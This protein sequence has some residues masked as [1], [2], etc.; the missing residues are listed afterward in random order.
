LHPHYIIQVGQRLVKCN[1]C[2]AFDWVH[3]HYVSLQSSATKIAEGLNLWSATASKHSSLT[4]A[5]WKTAKDMYKMIDA[6][7]IGSLPFKTHR[8]F[9]KGPKPSTPPHWMEEAYKLDARNVLAVVRDQ[10]AMSNFKDQFDYVPYQEFNNKGEHIWSNLMSAQ[11]AFKQAACSLC[12]VFQIAFLIPLSG[13]SSHK[14]ER[15]TGLCLYPLLLEATRQ[16]YW[17]HRVIKNITLSTFQ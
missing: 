3:Y 4:G 7:Q 11:W 13:M 10:L 1:N 8:L 17:L 16:L 9:Y 6:I 15:T 2:L 12:V 14:I 5:P